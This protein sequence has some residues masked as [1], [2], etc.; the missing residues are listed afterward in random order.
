MVL[1]I[2]KYFFYGVL[3]GERNSTARSATDRALEA[4]SRRMS[5]IAVFNFFFLWSIDGL[6]PVRAFAS[7]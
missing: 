7:F 2:F 5:R 4:T 6:L 1:S 3:C